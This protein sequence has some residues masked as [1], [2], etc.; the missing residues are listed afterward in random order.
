MNSSDKGQPIAAMSSRI[1]GIKQHHCHLRE[2]ASLQNLA[3]PGLVEEVDPDGTSRKHLSGILAFDR[4]IRLSGGTQKTTPVGD[5]TGCFHFN[6]PCRAG[7]FL[8]Q[9]KAYKP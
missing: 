3:I 2:K 4:W 9:N 1:K 7:A 5:V 6:F 8:S